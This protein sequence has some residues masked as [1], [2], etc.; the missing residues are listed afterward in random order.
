MLQIDQTVISLDI[1]EKKFVCNL[2][3]CKGACCVLGDSGA[4]LKDEEINKLEEIL[5]EI[6]PFMRDVGIK[7]VES[8]GCYTI[9]KDGDKVTPLVN[10]EECAFVFFE[11]EIAKCAIEKAYLAKKIDFQKP[12]SCHLYPI[13]STKYATFE[14]L[15]YHQWEICKPAVKNGEQANTPLFAFLKQPLTREFGEDWFNQLEI[16]AKE[17]KK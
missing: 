8:V 10:G 17:L 1:L 11:N 4:P 9:D 15:N 12:V 13:R 14:A 3:K 7:E 2:E 5:P 6:K 16:A